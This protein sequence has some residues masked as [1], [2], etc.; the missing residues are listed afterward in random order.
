MIRLVS[1]LMDYAF[2]FPWLDSV[3]KAVAARITA[4]TTRA[5]LQMVWNQVPQ[6][7]PAAILPKFPKMVKQSATIVAQSMKTI[8]KKNILLFLPILPS[9]VQTASIA[10]PA[11][12]WLA[13]PNTLQ[14]WLRPMKPM[15][16]PM[17]TM[18]SVETIGVVKNFAAPV[19][20][21]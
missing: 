21:S 7:A 6:S 18:I 19:R 13:E 16:Q 20:S 11:S 17:M 1:E 12:S 14:I 3:L 5:M 10:T 9:H 15:P 4:R 2:F 8:G